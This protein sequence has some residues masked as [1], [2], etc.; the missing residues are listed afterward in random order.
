VLNW[1]GC[2]TFVSLNIADAWLTN[3]LPASPV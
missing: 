3:Q 2:A 1:I